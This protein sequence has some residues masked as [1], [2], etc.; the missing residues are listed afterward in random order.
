MTWQCA[1]MGPRAGGTCIGA[2]GE[3]RGGVDKRVGRGG[4]GTHNNAN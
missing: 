1:V 4:Q 2:F 3:G